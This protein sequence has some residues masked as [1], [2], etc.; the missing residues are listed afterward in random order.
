MP[1]S[2]TKQTYLF[3]SYVLDHTDPDI[4]A[5][6]RE[7]RETHLINAKV[8]PGAVMRTSCSLDALHLLMIPP[9]MGGALMDPASY[10][11]ASK[12]VIGSAA[13]FESESLE[14][15]RKWLDEDIYH[16]S[17]V[18]SEFAQIATPMRAEFSLSG[19]GIH[20]SFSRGR[21]QPLFH[22]LFRNKR[23][24]VVRSQIATT[25]HYH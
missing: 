7:V 16:T 23:A 5:R 17:G 14:T 25:P 3:F 9:G 13:V 2:E 19:T 4:P 8:R 20:L 10:Q 1:E 15:L 22:P 18:V 21:P 6:R 24:I 11:S 12:R